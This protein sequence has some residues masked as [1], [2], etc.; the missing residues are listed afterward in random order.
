MTNK[1]TW[2]ALDTVTPGY[3]SPE[4]AAAA[5]PHPF[6]PYP[7]GQYA[8]WCQVCGKHADTYQH[9]TDEERAAFHAQQAAESAQRAGPRRGRPPTAEPVITLAELIRELAK[10]EGR[11]VYNATGLAVNII[12][13]AEEARR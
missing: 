10:Y 5:E 6:Q 2:R 1:D 8:R 12:R 11:P 3:P 13:A 7:A 4:A 9:A